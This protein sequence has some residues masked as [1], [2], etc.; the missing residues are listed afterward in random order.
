MADHIHLFEKI[1][2]QIASSGQPATEEEKLDWF[3]ESVHEDTYHAIKA[4][5][6][7]LKILG[8]LQF[9]AKRV[10]YD[11][12]EDDLTGSE[13][14]D[15]TATM[16]QAVLTV[17]SDNEDDSTS[18]ALAPTPGPAQDTTLDDELEDDEEREYYT[19]VVDG[20]RSLR[21]SVVVPPDSPPAPLDL[22]PQ[23]N[24]ENANEPNV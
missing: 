4:H 6:N 5:C 16:F 3:L 17:D 21:Y 7:S 8:T 23:D 10:T 24:N 13:P 20:V 9:T 18:L 15:E 14:D 11:A 2:G 19:E 1:C 22:A 12:D